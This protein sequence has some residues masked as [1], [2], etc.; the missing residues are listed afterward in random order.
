MDK[1]GFASRKDENWKRE[2]TLS[3]SRLRILNSE[4]ENYSTEAASILSE[5]GDVING[6]LQREDLLAALPGLDILIVRLAHQ[7]DSELL[8]RANRLKAIVTA[9]TGLDHI[10][11]DYARSKGITVLSLSGETDFL[12]R[13]PATAEHTW[14]LLLALVRNL[15]AAI[16]SVLNGGWDRDRF[17]GHDLAGRKLGILGMGRIGEKVAIYAN[18]FNMKVVAFDTERKDWPD[19]VQRMT[20]QTDLFRQSEILSIHVP[21]N[22]ATVGIIDEPELAQ[23]PRGALLVNTSR[24]QIIAEAAL[25]QALESGQIGGAALDVLGEE[26]RKGLVDSPLIRYAREHSNLLITPHIGGATY[27][28]MAAT[29]IFMAKKLKKFLKES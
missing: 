16:Q 10:D 14:A 18:A 15:P 23:L 2:P 8:E 17:K 9:T 13:I 24:G 5:L 27:E 6:P 28:S 12:R 19:G 20:N 3:M 22:S 1:P 21:L 11:L 29:E 4:P 26:R 25:L 7:I